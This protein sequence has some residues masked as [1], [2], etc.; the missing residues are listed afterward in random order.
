MYV[1]TATR[2]TKDGQEIRYLQLAH[3]EW[4]ADAQRSR[5]KVLHSFGR[6]DQFDRAAIERLVVSLAGCSI[7]TVPQC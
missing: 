6:A 7:R 2:R 3:N 5:T 1:K 4:D